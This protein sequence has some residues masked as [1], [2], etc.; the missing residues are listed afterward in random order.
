MK[1]GMEYPYVSLANFMSY[2]VICFVTCMIWLFI[3]Y[4]LF[5]HRVMHEKT[6]LNTVHPL[7][8]CIPHP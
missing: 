8:S 2:L 1:Y 4:V 3:N 6:T 7:Y 5:G